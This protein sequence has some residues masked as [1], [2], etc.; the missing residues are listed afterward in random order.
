MNLRVIGPLVALGMLAIAVTSPLQHRAHANPSVTALAC[1]PGSAGGVTAGPAPVGM[2]ADAAAV[3]D[4]GTFELVGQLGGPVTAVAADGSRAFIGLGARVVA[5]DLTDW[6]AARPA[7]ETTALANRIDDLAIAE[8]GIVVAAADFGGLRL[9]DV[10]DPAVPREVGRVEGTPAFGDAD[11]RRV[12][13]ADGFAYL[14]STTEGLRVFDIRDPGAPR[15]LARAAVPE[16]RAI[17][18]AAGHAWIA[19]GERGLRVWDVADPAA[20]REVAALRPWWA[21]DVAVDGDHVVVAAWDTGGLIYD[22]PFPEVRASALVVVDARHP[23]APRPVGLAW[24]PGTVVGLAVDG[25]HGHVLADGWSGTPVPYGVTGVLGVD[26]TSPTAPRIVAARAM[27]LGRRIAARA[28]RVFVAA[29][30]DGLAVLDAGRRTAPSTLGRLVA[31]ADAFELGRGVAMAR[32]DGRAAWAATSAGLHA[33]RLDA[34]GGPRVDGSLAAGWHPAGFDLA[35]D[36]AIVAAGSAGLRVVD[37]SDPRRPRE[38]GVLTTTWKAESVRVAGTRA[39]VAGGDGLLHL[40]YVADP[41]AP[42]ELGAV[43]AGGTLDA[44]PAGADAWAVAVE[45]GIAV[46][47]ARDPAAPTLAGRVDVAGRLVALDG[48][49]SGLVVAAVADGASDTWHVI[50]A[51]DPAAPRVAAT[52]T[53]ADGITALDLYDAGGAPND[54]NDGG[55][56]RLYLAQRVAAAFGAARQV[57]AWSLRDPADPA[58]LGVYALGDADESRIVALAAAGDRL[59]LW[60]DQGQAW[61]VDWPA[62]GGPMAGA[63]LDRP[64]LFGA[65]APVD[66]AVLAAHPG[67]LAAYDV[68]VPAAPAEG[69]RVRLD[70][71]AS[72]TAALPATLRVD[73]PRAYMAVSDTAIGIFDVAERAAPRLLAVHDVGRTIGALDVAAGRAYVAGDTGGVAILDVRDAGAVREV[74]AYTPPSGTAVTG[75]TVVGGRAYLAVFDVGLEIVDVRDPAAPVRVGTLDLD[76]DDWFDIVVAGRTLLVAGRPSP[77]GRGWIVDAADP[78]A[79]R[80]LGVLPAPAAGAQLWVDPAVPTRLYAADGQRVHVLD[81]ADPAHPRPLAEHMVRRVVD[82]R[83]ADGRLYALTSGGSLAV[84]A[85]VDDPATTPAA[86][87]T[88]ATWVDASALDVAGGRA[89]VAGHAGPL[90]LIDVRDPTRPRVTAVYSTGRVADVALT[91]GHAYV[92]GSIAGGIEIVDVADPAAPRQQGRIALDGQPTAVRVAAARAYALLSSGRSRSLA[93]VDV[94]DPAHPALLGTAGLP[95]N[96]SRLVVDGAAGQRVHVLSPAGLLTLDTGDLAAIVARG[97]W[98]APS[99]ASLTAL[100]VDGATAFVGDRSTLRV[101][102]VGAADAPAALAA[103]DL[104]LA[105]IADIA[106]SAEH[107]H[108]GGGTNAMGSVTA[109]DRRD[110]GAPAVSGTH[111]AW[112]SPVRLRAAGGFVIVGTPDAG[113]WVLRWRPGGTRLWLPVARKLE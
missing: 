13:V 93:V 108:V 12:A 81:I 34:P 21:H 10:R 79:P 112:W 95:E 15:E 18:V 88:L 8:D 45:G 14:V 30:G 27:P 107:L 62:A 41:H 105:R 53:A 32:M 16:A 104:G 73:G 84:L 106:A 54:P 19:A 2:A 83:A 22:A 75:V 86:R 96:A 11:E 74:G 33:F 69:G 87:S 17:A 25:G 66:G 63:P 99:R 1:T 48:T 110:P 65:M 77:E 91:V 58:P 35:G 59:G 94:A 101:V 98:P 28:G 42:R 52:R 24:V 6:P 103:L 51:R 68:S 43:D 37:V 90:R 70:P 55:G 4:T 89:A 9:V 72:V 78:A 20:P 85:D 109:V 60:N 47:D 26:L 61:A 5:L 102:D 50:D 71:A 100:A 3:S 44:V 7:G 113:V 38:V 36:H 80:L 57:S 111:R 92:A 40:V 82:V 23:E 39:A 56:P 97:V 29:A 49:A 76:I 67:G 64:T 31:W 46:V